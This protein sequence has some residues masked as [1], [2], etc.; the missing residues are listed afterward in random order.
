MRPYSAGMNP[1]LSD[2]PTEDLREMLRAT[3]QV[4][5]PDS[6]S[7]RILRRA[8]ESRDREADKTCGSLS[9]EGPAQ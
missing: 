2:L 5:G 6:V 4:A 9:A 1:H 7:A 3:E 8:L